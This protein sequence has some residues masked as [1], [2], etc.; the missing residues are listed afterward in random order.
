MRADGETTLARVGAAVRE[1]G[2]GALDLLLPRHCVACDRALDAGDR[3]TVCGRCWARLERLP[4]PCCA[5]CGHPRRRRPS[6]LTSEPSCAWCR[7]LPT[8]VRAVRS[9]CWVGGA[10][11][12][13]P[14]V[15]ALKYGGWES[16]ADGMAERMARVPWPADVLAER[17]VVLP[18]PLA[19]AR[20]RERGFNQSVLL[21]RALGARWDVAVAGDVLAR[22][23][24]TRT[25]TRLTPDERLAN[26]RGAFRAT[27]G[28]PARVR[29]RH[30]VLVDDVVTTCATLNACAAALFAC[31]ARIVSYATFGRARSDA[32]RS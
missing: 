8:Y 13:G 30:V 20:E 3:G 18:V 16:V 19:A 26:V 14:I 31:G 1:L 27:D 7:L 17:D 11:S 15:H 29:G 4:E 23:R 21:A 2:A 32:D 9:V 25:Q 10:G 12:G 6:V 22:G 5:R 28:A 24:A